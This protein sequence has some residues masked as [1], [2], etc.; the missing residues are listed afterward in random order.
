MEKTLGGTRQCKVAE[1]QLQYRMA[2]VSVRISSIEKNE[3]HVAPDIA[4]TSREDGRPAPVTPSCV[5]V[6]VCFLLWPCTLW[7]WAVKMRQLDT[8]C[9]PHLL[10][11][12]S[13]L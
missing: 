12:R 9:S 10:Q 11:F 13:Q 3:D 8:Y 4:T 6:C 7:V 1:L 5:C 2:E